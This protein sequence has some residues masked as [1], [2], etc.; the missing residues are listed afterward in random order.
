[1]ASLLPIQMSECYK[2]SAYICGMGLAGIL[3]GQGC[4]WLVKEIPTYQAKVQNTYGKRAL[5]VALSIL[6][7]ASSRLETLGNTLVTSGAMMAVYTYGRKTFTL[8]AASP[9][10]T[11]P[12]PLFVRINLFHHRL[13]L[14]PA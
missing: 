5:N 7:F 2:L 8:P 10:L 13:H 11:P 12:Q 4:Q 9:V 1:M 14:R 6:N 3:A